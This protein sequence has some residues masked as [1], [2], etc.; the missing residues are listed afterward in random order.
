MTDDFAAAL[1]LARAA[2]PEA[3]QSLAQLHLPLV[4]ALARRIHGGDLEE[5]CQQGVIGLMKALHSFDVSRGTA[6]STYAVPLIL[7]EIRSLLR[8][9]TALHIPRTERELRRRIH[10]A[11]ESLTSTLH[12]VPT[13]FE[14]AETMHM[15]ADDL[16]LHTEDITLASMDDEKHA[17]LLPDTDDW[18]QRVELRDI[19]SKLPP[20]DQH[21]I[22]LRHRAGMTQAQAG[23]RLGMTQMQVSRREKI[24]RTLLKRAL[25]E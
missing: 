4:R 11:E 7:G 12:R 3:L 20:M 14:L 15:D 5:K 17:P 2:G 23:Q 9:Q 1:T 8:Q 10:S 25:S 24:I 19:L 22:L 18:Q 6:F 16:L 13:V 21:L